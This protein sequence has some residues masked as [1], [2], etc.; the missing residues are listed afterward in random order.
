[1]SGAWEFF[2]WNEFGGKAGSQ[3]CVQSCTRA[4][5]KCACLHLGLSVS[6]ILMEA[7]KLDQIVMRG[8]CQWVTCLSFWAWNNVGTHSDLA[9]TFHWKSWGCWCHD[10]HRIFFMFPAINCWKHMA[11]V[12]H[13]CSTWWIIQ[14]HMQGAGEASC[15]LLADRCQWPNTSLVILLYRS[16]LYSHVRGAFRKPSRR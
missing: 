8:D 10:W 11:Q 16:R 14:S 6:K 4:C 15:Q 13:N 3:A 9:G 5:S 12:M 7:C 2:E 1:M